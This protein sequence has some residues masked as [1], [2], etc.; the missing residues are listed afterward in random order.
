MIKTDREQIEELRASPISIMPEDVLKDLKDQQL[1][2]L[3]A[4]LMSKPKK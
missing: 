1:R 2:D 4:Y 3:F